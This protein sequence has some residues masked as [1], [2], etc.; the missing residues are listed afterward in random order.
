MPVPERLAVLRLDGLASRD[1][2]LAAVRQLVDSLPSGLTHLAV[3]PAVD[4][5]E[6]RA[7]AADWRSR[8]AEYEVLADPAFVDML[9]GAGARRVGWRDL[10]R[11]KGAR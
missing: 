4:T 2:R 1:E 9:D 10:R 7:A 5:P 11:G 8:V 6:L 3:H